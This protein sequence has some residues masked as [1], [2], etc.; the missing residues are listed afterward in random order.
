LSSQKLVE[1]SKMTRAYFQGFVEELE[2]LH[3]LQQQ[4]ELL[5]SQR[6]KSEVTLEVRLVE[7]EKRS[8]GLLQLPRLVWPS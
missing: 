2:L 5:R 4:L 7:P 8:L 1:G 3:R 6:S